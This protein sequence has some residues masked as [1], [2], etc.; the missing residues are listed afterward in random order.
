MI[1]TLHDLNPVYEAKL[2]ATKAALMQYFDPV[3]SA[4]LANYSIYGSLQTQA[5]LWGFIEVFRLFA[6]AS[7]AIIPLLLLLKTAKNKKK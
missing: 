5:S 3:S 1:S 2:N 6:I 7:F 4:H